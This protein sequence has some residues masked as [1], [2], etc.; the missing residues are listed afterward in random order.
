MSSKIELK[1]TKQQQREPKRAET[2]YI[3]QNR[4]KKNAEG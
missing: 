4:T 3:K 2:V 1:R